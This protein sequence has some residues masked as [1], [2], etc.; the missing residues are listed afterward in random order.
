MPG[1]PG[2]N[3]CINNIFF[4]PGGLHILLKEIIDNDRGRKNVTN[5]RTA[6]CNSQLTL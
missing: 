2:A 5:Q 4:L 3:L 6:H 1:P